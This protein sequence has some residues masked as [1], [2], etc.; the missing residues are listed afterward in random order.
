MR[1]AGLRGSGRCWVLENQGERG[2]PTASSEPTGACQ[3]LAARRQFTCALLTPV[4]LYF[5]Q[6]LLLDL[7]IIS[8]DILINL[9]Y[10]IP[11][12]N[13]AESL[14]TA[15]SCDSDFHNLITQS[16]STGKV[17]VPPAGSRGSI[18]R[19]VSCVPSCTGGTQG[20]SPGARTWSGAVSGVLIPPSGCGSVPGLAAAVRRLL[21]RKAEP[22]ASRRLAWPVVEP[23]RPLWQR[24][25][26]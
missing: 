10:L 18:S 21:R 8:L 6:I 22:P 14:A 4:G 3:T 5:F 15:T 9:N 19:W 26:V 7:A 20:V 16:N 23:R 12:V 13:T 25:A 24:A 1:S 2:A 11:F 17:F